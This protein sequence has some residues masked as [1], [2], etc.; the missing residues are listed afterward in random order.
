MT[1]DKINICCPHCGQIVRIMD[2]KIGKYEVNC[3]GCRVKIIVIIDKDGK[4][5]KVTK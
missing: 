4:F 2:F 5:I 1:K 3:P